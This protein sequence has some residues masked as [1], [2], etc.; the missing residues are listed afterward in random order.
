MGFGFYRV[1]KLAF[2]FR[3]KSS[4][5]L[6]L[7]LA[8]SISAS[9]VKLVLSLWRPFLGHFDIRTVWKWN[10]NH[11]RTL[12][13]V[14]SDILKTTLEVKSQESMYFWPQK[15][16][17][18]MECNVMEWN[19]MECNGIWNSSYKDFILAWKIEQFFLHWIIKNIASFRYKAVEAV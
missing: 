14:A 6:S 4:H 16:A 7:A 18:A 2:F 13:N 19:V 10:Q 8:T 5:L 15:D 12:W 1:F 9:E 17:K 11:L 3:I